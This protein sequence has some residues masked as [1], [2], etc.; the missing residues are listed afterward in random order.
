MPNAGQYTFLAH[1]LALR[2][3]DLFL[4]WC[5]KVYH[6]QYVTGQEKLSQPP[7][8]AFIH[9]LPGIHQGHA[10]RFQLSLALGLQSLLA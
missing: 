3:R 5:M 1:P 9:T 2:I 4:P 7:S 6:I 8:T 10:R